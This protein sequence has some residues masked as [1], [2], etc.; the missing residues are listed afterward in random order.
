MRGRGRLHAGQINKDI[1]LLFEPWD[2]LGIYRFFC[3]IVDSSN[4]SGFHGL[5][6]EDEDIEA[7]AIDWT[8]FSRNLTSGLYKDCKIQLGG[9]W[10]LANRANI[11]RDYNA[12]N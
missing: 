3:G 8:E 12:Q 10:L 9:Y 7:K 11:L 2:A 1:E 4:A 5:D 6:Q